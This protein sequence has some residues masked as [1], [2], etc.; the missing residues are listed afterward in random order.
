MQDRADLMR[1]YVQAGYRNLD[2][3]R[4]HY[5]Q[6][7]QGGNLYGGEDP[8]TT[9]Q[10]LNLIPPKPDI[11]LQSDKT[12]YVPQFTTPSTPQERDAAIKN[13]AIYM[14]ITTPQE[15]QQDANQENFNEDLH[16]ANGVMG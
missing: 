2:E 10:Q 14:A 8:D 12:V 6:F 9:T 5:N 15:R 7:S 13:H 3:I 16:G 4:N 1:I 11:T